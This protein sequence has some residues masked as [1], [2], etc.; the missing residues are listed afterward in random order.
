M[1]EKRRRSSLLQDLVSKRA[2]E[3]EAQ[4]VVCVFAASTAYH[5]LRSIK[6]SLFFHNAACFIVC[7]K[8]ISKHSHVP[9]SLLLST[10][11]CDAQGRQDIMTCA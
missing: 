8:Q 11:L 5:I 2:L 10:S 3:D 4:V 9:G 1:S 7:T 6:I